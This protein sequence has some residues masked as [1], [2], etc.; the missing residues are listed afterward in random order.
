MANNKNTAVSVTGGQYSEEDKV[1]VF[2]AYRLEGCNASATEHVT[3][4]PAPTIRRWVKEWNATG[5]IPGNEA[6]VEQTF[7]GFAGKA[8]K[9]RDKAL[10]RLEKEID[11]SNNI[12]Q[13]LQ[14]VDKLDNKVRVSAGQ[15]TSI[16]EERKVDADSISA[17][18]VKYIEAAAQATIDRHEIV[19]D[20]DF[21]EQVL[22]IESTDTPETPTKD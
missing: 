17:A 9:I 21:E 16:V 11:N 18:L 12:G 10:A 7:N 20:A 13:L 6:W 19:Y 22:G 1:A 14:V 4:V 15:A 3:G 8:V 2:I 5:F